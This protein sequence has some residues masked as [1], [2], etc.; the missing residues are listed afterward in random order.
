METLSKEKNSSISNLGFYLKSL[1]LIP[2]LAQADLVFISLLLEG[3]QLK[4]NNG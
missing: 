4:N 2:E 3:L 1:K